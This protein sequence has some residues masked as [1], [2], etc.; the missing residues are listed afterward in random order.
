MQTTVGT[1]GSSALL[2]QVF[3]LESQALSELVSVH[4]LAAFPRSLLE[5]H[6]G[7]K[8][9]PTS[10]LNKLSQ[11]SALEMKVLFKSFFL[12]GCTINK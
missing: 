7:L 8:A 12:L 2:K 6:I 9:I 5:L 10:A 4:L 3:M 1:I 11:T